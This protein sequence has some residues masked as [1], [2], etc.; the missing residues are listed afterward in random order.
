M[1]TLSDL[2]NILS[3]E[4]KEKLFTEKA[5]REK[6]AIE[7]QKKIDALAVKEM[8]L[9]YFPAFIRINYPELRGES[10]AL[11]IELGK[12]FKKYLK[13]VFKENLKKLEPIWD[14]DPKTVVWKQMTDPFSFKGYH[15]ALLL[16]LCDFMD[17]MKKENPELKK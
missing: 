9:D 7:A 2:Q 15:P 5:E 3:E 1:N 12:E 16:H 10:N 8:N 6:Q 14:I 11:L 17:K 13:E 4:E